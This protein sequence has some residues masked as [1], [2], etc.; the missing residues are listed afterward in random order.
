MLGTTELIIILL[1]VL[2]IFGAG[3]LRNIGS[4]LGAAVKNFKDG[5][6]S[7]TKK[8]NIKKKKK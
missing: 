1:V 4:D 7:E 2:V 6:Q 3:K 5:M 8:N